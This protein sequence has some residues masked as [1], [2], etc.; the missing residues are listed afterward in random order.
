MRIGIIGTGNI[1]G[2]LARKL[3]AAGHDVR[4]ANTRGVEGAREL[5]DAAKATAASLQDVVQDVEVVIL[6]IP[7]PAMR[8]LPAGLFDAVAPTVAVIDTSN[9]YPGMRDEP[10]AEIDEG[11]AE[12]IWVVR[13]IG[14]PVIKS[15]NN[16]LAYSLAEL[17]RP[18]GATD[19]LAIAVAGD[20]EAAKQTAMTLVDDIGFDAVDAGSLEESWRQQPST[21]AY[22]CDDNADTMRAALAAA[23]KGE[24]AAKRDRLPAL[25]AELGPAPT[26]ADIVAM[27]RRV[28]RQVGGS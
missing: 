7:L 4:V 1:G 15:F 16:I 3:V 18:A 17:G 26:H 24:A 9:Y 5:A 12:S 28:N 25:F 13:Q 6:A 14:R 11:T 22:C 10:I 19:R 27:N 8:D 21:P 2:T 20:D 23:V